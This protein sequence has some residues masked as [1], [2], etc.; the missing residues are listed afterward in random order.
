MWVPALLVAALVSAI[1]VQPAVAA[2]RH[3]LIAAR[4]SE[5]ATLAAHPEDLGGPAD[6][7]SALVFSPDGKLPGYR[8]L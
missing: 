3:A 7:L 4:V 5:P 6:S 1:S 2:G 8:G